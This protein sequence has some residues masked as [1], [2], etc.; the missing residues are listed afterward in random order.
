M[1]KRRGRSKKSY[2]GK[3]ESTQAMENWYLVNLIGQ[4]SKQKLPQ[5]IEEDIHV[6]FKFYFKHENFFT[7][8]NKRSMNLPDLSNLY[9][10]PSHDRA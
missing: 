5:T 3:K 2:V 6:V 9:E 10:F 7:K 4:S 8:K 1:V